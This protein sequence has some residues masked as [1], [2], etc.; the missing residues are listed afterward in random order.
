MDSRKQTGTMKAKQTIII[1]LFTVFLLLVS[2]APDDSSNDNNVAQIKSI[3]RQDYSGDQ[4]YN[5]QKTTFYY[6]GNN[7]MMSSSLLQN[8]SSQTWTDYIRSNYTLSDSNHASQQIDLKWNIKTGMWVNYMRHTFTYNAQG[9]IV[10][11][12]QEI[13][14]PDNN[15][16]LRYKIDYIYDNNTFLISKEYSEWYAASSLWGAFDKYVYT[17]NA[18]GKP[19]NTEFINN[20]ETFYNETTTYDINGFFLMSEQQSQAFDGSTYVNLCTE[21]TTNSNGNINVIT[22]TFYESDGTISQRR[23]FLYEYY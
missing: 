4:W 7:T 10:K 5:T 23:R 3:V 12:E 9:K 17:N 6:E 18:Q 14:T 8:S 16:I 21:Q 22:K 1:S 13:W 15:W 20:G 11:E 2:C 19:V